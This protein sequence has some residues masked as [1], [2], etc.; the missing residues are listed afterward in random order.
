MQH[1]IIEMNGERCPCFDA[2]TLSSAVLVIC[3]G[4]EKCE[5]KSLIH[6]GSGRPIRNILK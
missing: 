3:S 1:R 5:Y 2:A 6:F 4:K